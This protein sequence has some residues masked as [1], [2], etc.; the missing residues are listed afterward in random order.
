MKS[1]LREYVASYGVKV[2]EPLL[3]TSVEHQG[4]PALAISGTNVRIWNSGTKAERNENRPQNLLK[5]DE[6]PH[7]VTLEDGRSVS[8][9]RNPAAAD[10]SSENYGY[11]ALI[12]DGQRLELSGSVKMLRDGGTKVSTFESQD[13]KRFRLVEPHAMA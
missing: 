11:K 13:G 6:S 3:L 12:L 2:P 10:S 8:V 7:A 1:I 9:A 5:P 4:H